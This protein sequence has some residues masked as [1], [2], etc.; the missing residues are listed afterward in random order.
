VLD[1]NQI[2]L[3]TKQDQDNQLDFWAKLFKAKTWEDIKMVTEKNPELIPA[4]EE[5]FLKNQDDIIKQQC[6]AR[7]E[8]YAIQKY[9]EN[10][11]KDLTAT[12]KSQ[13]SGV[14]TIFGPDI[15]YQ[16]EIKCTPKKK[17]I[18]QSEHIS[19][20]E[21]MQ[22]KRSRNSVIQLSHH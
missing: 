15:K 9:M 7:E 2:D 12:I 18:L 13:E 20:M 16:E 11:I 3:A 4:T 21:K 10:Q 17:K 8:Y 6:R 14:R 1:L 5:L 19:Q 22:Q